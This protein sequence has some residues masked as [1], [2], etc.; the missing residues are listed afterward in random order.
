MSSLKEAR[1]RA[2][3]L[4]VEIARHD[5]R[6]Y[7]EAK[8]E[9]SD[10]E[11]DAL[12]RELK[13]LESEHEELITS[14]SPTQRV[15]A[16]LSEGESFNKVEHEVPML[17][18]DSLF[19]EEEVREFE[20]R[21]LRFIGEESGDELEWVAEPKFDGVSASLI[22]ED[23]VFVRGITRGDGR[24]GEDVTQN[25]RTVRNL[26]LV[27]DTSSGDVPAVLE[28]R[29]EVL[30]QLE[31]FH[32]FNEK[33]ES[34]GRDRLANP[35][36]AAAGALRRNDPSSV[37]EYPLEF[38][39]WSAPRFGATEYATQTAA[40]A[41]LERW[42]LP[43]SKYGEVVSGL[44]AC[45][46][47][48]DRMEEK[49]DGIPFE[50]D[51]V[52]AKLNDLA[53]RARLG[54][55]ARAMR[56]QFAHKFAA[57]EVSTT[58]L[59]IEASVGTNGRLTPRAHVEAVE[60]GGVVVRHTTL[61]NAE[62]VASLGV[63][64]GDRVF[65]HRAG[66]VIPQVNGVAKA[67]LGKAPKDWREQIPEELIDAD[68][69]LQAGVTWEWAS[70]Y[71]VPAGC[72]ACGTA[73]VQEGKYWR[74]P[75]TYGCRPQ[76][77]GRTAH[78]AG[79]SGF[80]IDR[81][82]PKQIA[83][84]F[85]HGLIESPG[86]LFHLDQDM[87]LR[88][89]LV[90][91]ERWGEKSVVGLFAQLVERRR[92]DF[93]R[94]LAALAVPDVGAQTGRLLASHFDS[95]A[96]LR[97]TCVEELLEVDGIGPEVGASIVDWLASKEGAELLERLL[98]G[99]VEI[100]YPKPSE[101]GGAFEAKTLVFTGSMEG[102]TRAEAKQQAEAAGGRVASSVSKKTDYLVVGGK[103]GSKAKKA[104]ELGVRVLLEG[105]FLKFLGR[106]D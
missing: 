62:H 90:N 43:F 87:F 24:V 37:T 58:L 77:V 25:L 31:R 84:L 11:Y 51:G 10:K 104:E 28:V 7:N 16:P 102:I 12:F 95:L 52:V 6:Y 66:D 29:G 39:T 20:E 80:E 13:E 71:E 17:S 36:N 97:A 48:H 91:L 1:Q 4:R 63:K 78:L 85:E 22:Y 93:A 18:I 57:R 46:A 3:W 72:P 19:A 21:L 101:G 53:L 82:G 15:G 67:A 106:K 86:D 98:S 26:P 103:P 47:Y 83:Q 33:R 105:E 92:V 8:P 100:V 69:E 73:P 68:G 41:A 56:W 81:I 5:K 44:D 50:I 94:F 49:R 32:A 96:D 61:H 65:V 79:R 99:G 70:A 76:I 45:I 75:N 89:R 14:D 60:L 64:I 59:A 74:C 2:A 88:E 27:L 9:V 55:T 40:N 23:G 42:G 30:I 34:D 35:R 54:R 38:H